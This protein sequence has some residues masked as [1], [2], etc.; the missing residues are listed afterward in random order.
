MV[1]MKELA[2]VSLALSILFAGISPIFFKL[3][4]VNIKKGPYLAMARAFLMNRNAIMGLILYG[5]SSV[6]WLV[7]LSYL[8][9]SLMYPLLS[10]AYVITTLLAAAYLRESVAAIRWVGV[11]LIV[12][13]SILV[14]ID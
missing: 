8:E 6:L 14:G 5:A 10:L 4:V 2:Y 7:S 1:V 3:A 9:V 11:L 13:G 12:L